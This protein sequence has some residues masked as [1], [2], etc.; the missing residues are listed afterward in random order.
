MRVDRGQGGGAQR[1]AEP[2]LSPL[3]EATLELPRELLQQPPGCSLIHRAPSGGEPRLSRGG[4]R[5]RLPGTHAAARLRRKRAGEGEVDAAQRQAALAAGAAVCGEETGRGEEEEAGEGLRGRRLRVRRPGG[6][7]CASV[8]AARRW[9]W[10]RWCRGTSS[11][12]HCSAAL[13]AGW[14]GSEEA[15]QPAQDRAL[16]EGIDTGELKKGLTLLSSE[17]A[18]GGTDSQMLGTIVLL[19]DPQV[20]QFHLM[21][22]GLIFSRRE[23]I[24]LSSLMA[25][26][27]SLEATKQSTTQPP[28]CLTIGIKFLWNT[29]FGFLQRFM[30][31]VD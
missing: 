12:A 19:D 28:P 10:R 21:I 26:L 13:S 20:I 8:W 11:R 22:N 17:S 24:M 25:S 31:I 30:A 14:G 3:A 7:E 6:C 5:Q 15:K 18:K 27:S 4:K 2:P 1:L 16:R 9:R 29:I 23:E